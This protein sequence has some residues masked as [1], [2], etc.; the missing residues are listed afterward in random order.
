MSEP[1]DDVRTDAELAAE[2]RSLNVQVEALRANVAAKTAET[3]RRTK[4]LAEETRRRTRVLARFLVLVSLIG[5]ILGLFM[6]WATMD[7][8]AAIEESQRRWCPVVGPLAPRA[9]DPPPVGTPEQVQRSLR[10]RA[11]FSKLVDDFGCKPS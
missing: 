11:A 2:V 10:I 3:H 4:V 1:T 5:L 9:A 6:I 7:N 8:R